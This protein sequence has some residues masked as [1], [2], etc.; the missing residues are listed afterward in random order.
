MGFDSLIPQ[1][2]RLLVY[3]KRYGRRSVRMMERPSDLPVAI[4]GDLSPGRESVG[5]LHRQPSIQVF[6]EVSRV[7]SV[8]ALAP[9]VQGMPP[10]GLNGSRGNDHCAV[11]VPRGGAAT[12][13]LWLG[14]LSLILLMRRRMCCA[15]G[16]GRRQPGGLA[17]RSRFNGTARCNGIPVCG[18]MKDSKWNTKP[19]LRLLSVS[20]DTH[21]RRPSNLLTSRRFSILEPRQFSECDRI[22]D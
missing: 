7:G 10:W 19:P 17:W 3:L 2:S 8:L 18:T 9:G 12:R 13:H 5:R 6:G 20:R 1:F 4:P 11:S 15:L 22:F 14:P 21:D 16:D